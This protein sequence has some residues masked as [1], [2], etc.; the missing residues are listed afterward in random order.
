MDQLRYCAVVASE[1]QK[2]DDVDDLVLFWRHNREYLNGMRVAFSAENSGTAP[3][4]GSVVGSIETDDYYI[5]GAYSRPK[6]YFLDE[7]I[8]ADY[9][10]H[11]TSALQVRTEIV[12]DSQFAN[13]VCKNRS[14]W[15]PEPVSPG[16]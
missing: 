10:R 9:D 8:L 11:G 16:Q 14:I 6:V 12:L 5:R 15:T 3:P 2:I 4:F 7:N 1:L 13:Y